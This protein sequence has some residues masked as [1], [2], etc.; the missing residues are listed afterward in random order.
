MSGL[1]WQSPA[2]LL[3]DKLPRGCWGAALQAAKS[4]ILDASVAKP[5]IRWMALAP[6]FVPPHSIFD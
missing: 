5:S 2:P 6:V 4:A 3:L 1:T